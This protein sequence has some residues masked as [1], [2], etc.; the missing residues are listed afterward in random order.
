MNGRWRNWRDVVGKLIVCFTPLRESFHWWG[1]LVSKLVHLSVV[2]LPLSKHF[3]LHPSGNLSP[4]I[5]EFLIEDWV[6]SF[7]KGGP[8]GLWCN[9][10]RVWIAINSWVNRSRWLNRILLCVRLFLESVVV[11]E[12]HTISRGLG[13]ADWS[14]WSSWS[15]GTCGRWQS[16]LLVLMLGHFS[17]QGT[18]GWLS[19]VVLQLMSCGRVWSWALTCGVVLCV[20]VPSYSGG[21]RAGLCRSCH[22]NRLRINSLGHWE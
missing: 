20:G 8:D 10:P 18:F 6:A 1:R 7:L 5:V 4:D 12:G 11:V 22:R 9:V 19:A 14:D 17:G 15:C 16:L 21:Q 3:V 13:S 2:K